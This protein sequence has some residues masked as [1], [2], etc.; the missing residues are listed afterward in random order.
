MCVI[1]ITTSTFNV[2]NLD[3]VISRTKLKPIE[4]MWNIIDI[5]NKLKCEIKIWVNV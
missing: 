2:N 5:K 4:K 1:K 3:N